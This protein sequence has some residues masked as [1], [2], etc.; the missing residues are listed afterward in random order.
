MKMPPKNLLPYL[1]RAG[2]RPKEARETLRLEHARRFVDEIYGPDLHTLRVLSLG[3]ALAGLLNAAVLSVA[4]IGQAYANLANIKG[5]SGVK[6]VDRLL[7]NGGVVLDQ[8]LTAWVRHVVGD[9][10]SIVLALDWTEFD[11]DD[12][13]TLCAYMVTTHGRA[14]P[15]VWKTV[16]KSKLAGKRTDHERELL[17]RLSL[18]LGTAVGVTVL[19][20]RGFGDQK[21]YALLQGYGWNYVIRFREAILVEFE[22]RSRPASE[23]VAPNG[24]ARLLAGARVT[25]DRAEVGAVVTVKAKRMKEAWCLATSFST[26]KAQDI[27]KIYDRRF[28]IEEVFRDTKDLHFG[29]GLRATH[30]R[31]AARRD[32]MLLLVAMAHTLLTLLGAASEACGMDAYLKVNTVKKRTHSLFRQG[33]YWYQCLPN[34][35]EDWLERII[36]AYDKIVREHA[37]FS[38]VFAMK[39]PVVDAAK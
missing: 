19:A 28:T 25:K 8:V 15:L 36:A 37:F 38:Y 17:D 1:S 12:H 4:A 31:D 18:M 6:Q 30:I 35:R 34:M 14:M 21:L 23:W 10:P 13:S 26:L 3:N 16:K 32:R 2:R 33:L 11:D 5:K 7:S 20:D 39:G 27:V 24:H 9:F 29:M 22:G